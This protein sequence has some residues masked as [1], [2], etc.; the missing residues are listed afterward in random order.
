ME[1]RELMGNNRSMFILDAGYWILDIGCWMLD[2][3]WRLKRGLCHS[4][5]DKQNK[6][7]GCG[8]SD[9]IIRGISTSSEK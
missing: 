8:V 1:L 4:E 5:F 9:H 6:L 7:V 2:G 3:R